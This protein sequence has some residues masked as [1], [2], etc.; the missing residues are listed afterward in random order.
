MINLDFADVSTIIK[1]SGTAHMGMGTG[2]GNDRALTAA[3]KA[4]NSPLLETSIAG[5]TG[6]LI[7]VT[8][9][10]DLSLMEIDDAVEFIRQ[11]V[12]P[13]AEIIFGAS[14]DES[15][16]DTIAITLVATGLDKMFP[17][18]EVKTE[19]SPF[20]SEDIEIPTWLRNRRK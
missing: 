4:V 13:E 16:K 18:T 17:A 20:T 12:D 10:S 3:K 2:H 6:L 9:S 11:Q 1:N 15:M 14:I 5:A 8:G 19:E 7:N